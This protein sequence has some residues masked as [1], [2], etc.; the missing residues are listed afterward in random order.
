MFIKCGVNAQPAVRM[1]ACTNNRCFR[2]RA[3]G[4]LTAQLELKPCALTIDINARTLAYALQLKKSASTA[5]LC[6]HLLCPDVT[7]SVSP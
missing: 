7:V 1:P 2:F 4:N 6:Q 5:H 3:F